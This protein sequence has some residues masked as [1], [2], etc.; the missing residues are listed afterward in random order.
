MK[1]IK[2]LN[3]K[4]NKKKELLNHLYIKYFM[5]KAGNNNEKL[6]KEINNIIY[7]LEKL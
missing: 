2:I 3:D 4:K 6:K 5:V 1:T 7:N